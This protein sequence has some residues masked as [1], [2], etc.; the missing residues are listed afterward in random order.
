MTERLYYRDA[1]LD[2]FTA[3]IVSVEDDGRRV[4]LDRTAFYPTSGGQPHDTGFIATSPVVD[5]LDAGTEVVHVVA[6]PLSVGT[7]VDCV[8]D[9]T[10]R[11]DFMQ[12]H[13]GQHLLSALFAD[14]HGAET[15]SVHFGPEVSTIDLSGTGLTEAGLRDV[16]DRANA[17]VWVNHPITITFEDAATATGLRK[18]TEREGEIRVVEISGLDRSACG[19]T[20]V[21]G[22]SEIGAV[23]LRRHEKMKGNLRVE[24]ACGGR[25]LQHSRRDFHALN[26]I[27]HRLSAAMED[28][29]AHIDAQIEGMRT[30]ESERRQLR[31]TLDAFQAKALYDAATINA[32]GVRVCVETQP[33]GGNRPD[34]FRGRALA[35]T[36]HPRALYIVTAPSPPSVLIAASDDSGVDAGRRLREVLGTVGGRGGGSARLAQGSVPDAE[37]LT[38]AVQLLQEST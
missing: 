25:A 37:A 20:H 21:R 29:P 18:A 13:S 33:Q 23:M 35:F 24:F 28:V 10:R 15:V 4:T 5:V 27:A 38:K 19:G 26:G 16:E 17:S 2:R 31:E 7:E 11:Y 6:E 8:V 3:R 36:S 9:W 12:Q 1:Y 22:T 30:A 34:T 14:V 32:A